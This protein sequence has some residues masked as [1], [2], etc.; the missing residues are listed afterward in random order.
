VRFPSLK[1]KAHRRFCYIQYDNAEAAIAATQL[2]HSD[3]EGF[4]IVSKIS[5][6]GAKKDR[7]D[8]A[9]AEGREVYIW[10]LNFKV[11]EPEIKEAFAPFGNIERI[12]CPTTRTG[13][14]KGFCYIVYDTKE[15]A[16]AAVAEM[17]SKMY[18][19]LEM[20]V[21]IANDK[22][23]NK[24]KVRSTLENVDSPEDRE[25]T[26]GENELVPDAAAKR[27][28]TVMERSIAI[29]NLPDTVPDARIKPLVEPF[30]FKKITL[31]LQHG[32]AIIE[33][34][35]VEGAGKAEI[36]LQ[37]KDFEGR[38]LQIGTPRDLKQQKGEWKA[39]NNFVQPS[40][41]NRPVARGGSTA[42]RGRGKSGI[43]AGRPTIPKN[44]TTT[45]GKVK[46]NSDF[47]AMIMSKAPAKNG[48]K[49]ADKME[50]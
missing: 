35:S 5:N 46:S 23:E 41:V 49:D 15:S 20:H 22:A 27:T 13:T 44:A 7:R 11:K 2:D 26:P 24:P 39:S 42:G 16:D 50:E 38:K 30:G 19:G 6:P 12:K 32:G 4:K 37:G 17:D 8:G 45:N 33:F 31:L 1:Y 9:T 21:E 28:G 40:R 34:T 14:N 25:G 18:W 36:T 48:D 3:V 29:L 43:G 47:R 10:H